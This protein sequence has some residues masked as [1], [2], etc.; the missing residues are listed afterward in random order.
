MQSYTVITDVINL[1]IDSYQH[2]ISEK[3]IKQR[4][5]LISVTHSINHAHELIIFSKL[6]SS[7]PD[8]KPD[9]DQEPIKLNL[10]SRLAYHIKT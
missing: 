8:C 4:I 3:L 10:H 6:A 7:F 5:K 9:E 2:I 1:I